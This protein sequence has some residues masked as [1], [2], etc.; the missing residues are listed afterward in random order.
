[1]T[2]YLGNYGNIRLRRGTD[3]VLGSISS[4]VE[5]DDISL[6]LNRVGFENASENLLTGDRVDLTTTDSRGLVF[7]PASNWSINQIQDTFSCFVHVNEVG[8]LRLFPTFGDAVNNTRSNEITLQ[9]FSGSPLNLRLTIRDVK[10]SLLGCVSQFEFN[11][12]RDAIDVTSLSDKYK[13]QYDAGLLSG[14]GRI[15]C[16][17][18][19]ET[20]GVEEA[21]LLLLQIIQRLDIGCAFDLA[22]YLTDKAVDPTLQNLF[23][24][25][26]AVPTNTG[27]SLRSGDII[28]CTIDFVTTGETRLIFGVPS[29]YLL[30]EDDDR[31]KVEDSLDFLLKEVTD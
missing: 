5:P 29:D 13:R 20:T 15:E 26:T 4:D 6:V 22:L 8:G 23:Y 10:Y 3:P 17:F 14:S 18:N 30:K 21:P 12:N 31:I 2:F 16:A 9:S 27:I 7:I 28:T 1:M 24:L 11:A 25:L 19:Y